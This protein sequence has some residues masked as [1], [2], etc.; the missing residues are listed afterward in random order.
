FCGVLY[1]LPT[2]CQWRNLPSDFPNRKT[3]Y[4][5]YQIWRKVNENDTSLLEK[6]IK[7]LAEIYRE[8]DGGKNQTSLCVV[9]AQSV[10][11]T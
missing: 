3:V 1:L 10:K 6:C 4:A 11:N 7:K 8:Q 2:G 5:Y 9:D